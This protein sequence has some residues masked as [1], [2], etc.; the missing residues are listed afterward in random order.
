MN[1]D[2][3]GFA[4]A[5]LDQED[6]LTILT[7]VTDPPGDPTARA[8]HALARIAPG[9]PDVRELLSYPVRLE[10]V[11][12]SYDQLWSW[13][14]DI[15]ER[16]L[17]R[18]IAHTVGLRYANNRITV[19]FDDQES[20]GTGLQALAALGVPEDAVELRVEPRMAQMSLHLDSTFATMHAA[21][22]VFQRYDPDPPNIGPCTSGF[23]GVVGDSLVWLTG[24]HCSDAY[25]SS[26]LGTLFGQTVHHG[27]IPYAGY[28]VARAAISGCGSTEC[29]DADALLNY[30]DSVGSPLTAIEP[31]R[32]ARTTWMNSSGGAGSLVV[33]PTNPSFSVVQ[34]ATA[35]PL[36]GTFVQKVTRK[37]GWDNGR[38]SDNCR[39]STPSAS[40]FVYLCQ[41]EV[42]G[43]P[44][45]YGQPGDSGGPVF[46]NL[47]L[48]EARAV[49]IVVAA[50]DPGWD[51]IFSPMHQVR[52]ALGTDAVFT[53]DE[54]VLRVSIDGP[55]LIQDSDTYQWEAVATGGEGS[56]TYQWRVFR[57]GSGHPYSGVWE[58]LGTGVIQQLWVDDAG[59]DFTLEVTADDGVTDRTETLFVTNSVACDPEEIICE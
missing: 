50:T 8:R 4:G 22:V 45:M 48:G 41:V 43:S 19:A 17:H 56:Y 46:A 16:L 32:I 26:T 38:V 29:R 33:D 1:Q 44:G 37:T 52:G 3:D 35:A 20:L 25:P 10:T 13:R 47:G 58:T 12:Y 23:T 53:T 21:M 24:D 36:Q 5:Y 14:A 40:P 2:V 54:L 6:Q 57:H 7:T 59:G 39:T 27:N 28:T 42:A 55:V 49:G 34:E 15:E 51:V 30:A 9:R 18:G 31:A 11:A